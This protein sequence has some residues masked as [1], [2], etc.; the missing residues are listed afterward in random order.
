MK[1]LIRIFRPGILVA[2]AAVIAHLTNLP[3]MLGAHPWWADKVIWV[4]VPVGFSLAATA[5]ILQLPGGVRKLGFAGLTLVAFVLAQTGKMRFT[6]SYAE[7]MLAGQLW[8]FGWIATCALAFA[9]LA[10]ISW[11]SRQIH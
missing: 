1:Q 7:D 3:A 8:Y 6:A 2:L 10:S 5:W 11:A 4:G 9:T